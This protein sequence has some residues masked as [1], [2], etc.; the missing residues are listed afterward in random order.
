MKREITQTYG[1]RLERNHYKCPDQQ[2][3]ENTLRTKTADI[4]EK[5]EKIS[6]CR[7]SKEIKTMRDRLILKTDEDGTT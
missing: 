7:E 5:L 4:M 2:G 1:N 6:E 3:T